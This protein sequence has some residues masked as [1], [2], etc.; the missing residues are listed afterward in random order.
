MRVPRVTVDA[1]VEEGLVVELAPAEARHL[2][3]VLR[4]SPGDPV[5]VL[6]VGGGRWSAVISSVD[7]ERVTVRVGPAAEPDQSRGS[8][9]EVNLG[10][11]LV[12]GSAFELAVR[13]ATEL[14]VRS[15]AP[16]VTERT[17][18]RWDSPRKHERVERVAREAA[19][20][21]GRASPLVV[22]PAGSLG[23]WLDRAGGAPGLRL[24]LDP[25]GEPVEWGRRAG[26]SPGGL[27]AAIGPEGGFTPA[28]I[29]AARAA[30]W[31]SWALPTP[32]LRTPTAVAAVA[33]LGVLL[34][35]AG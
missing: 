19:K 35:S 24:I 9:G 23:D 8:L 27:T 6:P 31:T 10:I 11:A 2:A 18:V 12:R 17:V 33:A 13:M 4:R 16:L 15:V 32:V 26:E 30:G 22:E 21:C 34:G 7:G 29:A 20:Q 14:G 28:E 3:R 25:D 1:A 5:E